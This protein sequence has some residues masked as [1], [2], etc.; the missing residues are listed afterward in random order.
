MFARVSFAASIQAR[1]GCRRFRE[2]RQEASTVVALL[3]GVGRQVHIEIVP[4]QVEQVVFAKLVKVHAGE[5]IRGHDLGHRLRRVDVHRDG[6]RVPRGRLPV[7]AL[8]LLLLLQLYRL[9]VLL[10]HVCLLHLLHV[11]LLMLWHDSI[12]LRTLILRHGDKSSEVWQRYTCRQG[13]VARHL[14]LQFRVVGALLVLVIVRLCFDI[15]LRTVDR[16]EDIGRTLDSRHVRSHVFR[17]WWKREDIVRVVNGGHLR[18]RQTHHVSRV[19]FAELYHR[20]VGHRVVEAVE[21]GKLELRVVDRPTWDIPVQVVHWRWRS[22][23]RSFRR[24]H[25]ARRQPGSWWR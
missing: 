3:V 24:G 10:V 8:V 6:D 11:W 25:C 23:R 5:V 21:G 17:W 13:S 14:I 9:L 19:R 16:S 1:I 15:Q 2:R 4:G 12:L 18:G 22:P 20:V 7:V